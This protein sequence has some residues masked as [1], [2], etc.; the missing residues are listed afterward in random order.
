VLL[1]LDHITRSM[2][3]T[4][5][6]K[7]EG[8]RVLRQAMGY[9]WSVAAAASPAAARPLFVKWLRSSD[10]DISWVMKSNLGK[11]R[12]K[13]FRKDVEEPRVKKPAKKP[14]RKKPAA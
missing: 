13:G 12:L 11:A 3:A 10:P 9:C 14:V 4:R 8:F 1:V 7:H 5:D 2:A 6:R